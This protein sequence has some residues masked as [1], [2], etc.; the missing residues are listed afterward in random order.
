MILAAKDLDFK[1]IL[2]VFIYIEVFMLLFSDFSVYMGWIL[3]VVNMRT[4]NAG[5]RLSLGSVYPTDLAAR[6]F[7]ISLAYVTLK[8][9]KLKLPEYISLLAI[10]AFIY[11]VTDTKVDTLLILLLIVVSAFYNMVMKLLYRIG[12]NTI[13]LVAGAVVG[14]EI[15]LTYLYTANSRIF[16]IMDHIL[17]GRLKYG[18]MAFKDYNVTMFGQFIKEYANGGIHKEKFNYFF[19]D[20]SYL[21]VLMFGGIVAFVALVIM[22]IYLVN[23]FIHDKTICLL[24]AL[25]FAALSSLI[26]QH[27]MELSY[28]IIFIAML[29][30]NDYFKDKLV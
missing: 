18:H 23:K 12:A 6:I 27:L 10:C 16:N 14:I 1:Q 20:V 13:T 29:T 4:G 21:R 7:Y 19:I 8:K 26:D 28:N 2:K 5:I 15:V 11:F 22:L 30:N 9:F 25:L 17:S 3:E 24:L